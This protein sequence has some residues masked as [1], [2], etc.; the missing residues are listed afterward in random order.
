LSDPDNRPT[1]NIDLLRGNRN[2][3]LLWIAD[4]VS[5]LGDRVHQV[6]MAALVYTA[7]GSL[8]QTGIAFVATALPDLVIGPFAGVLVD[9][10]DRRRVLIAADLCRVPLVLLIPFVVELHIGLVYLLLFLVNAVSVIFKPARRAIVP[11]IVRPREYNT[12]NSLSSVSENS[13]DIVGYPLGGGMLLVLGGLLGTQSAIIVAFAF[14]AVSYLVSGLLIWAIAVE[15]AGEIAKVGRTVWSEFKEGV[16]FVWNHR[17]VLANTLVTLLGPIA[18]GASTPLLVGYAW[19]VLDGGE[20]EYSLI[21]AGIS[22]GT[23][24]GGLWLSTKERVPT[25][26]VVVS[27]LALMGAS[28]TTVAL[29]ESLWPAVVLIALSGFGSALVLIPGVTLVQDHTPDSLLGRVFS[30][31]AT[32]FYSAIVLSTFIG[33]WAGDRFGTQTSLLVCGIILM[34]SVALAALVPAVRA[35][36]LPEPA[37]SPAED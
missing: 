14:D 1:R 20:W 27:G 18:L 7:T 2:F 33:G 16:V 34:V 17:L 31:R 21:G 29:V 13:S 15:R 32:L 22:T 26:M 19:D 28:V 30:L 24:L 10:M 6:A 9:R 23:V 5:S 4:F 12:A 11:S 8:T 37:P 35:S 3:A 36:G 25:G